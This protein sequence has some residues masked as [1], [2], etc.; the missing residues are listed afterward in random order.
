MLCY[1]PIIGRTEIENTGTNLAF[2]DYSKS[3]ILSRFQTSSK[4]NI[5][6]WCT[7]S[8]RTMIG[9]YLILLSTFLGTNRA[10]AFDIEMFDILHDEKHICSTFQSFNVRSKTE[11]TGILQRI[12]TSD[13]QMA[14]YFKDT[15]TCI[16][17]TGSSRQKV[18]STDTNIQLI[19]AGYGNYT[20]CYTFS[21][22]LFPSL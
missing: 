21:L 10:T 3:K 6:V 20:F 19:A 1:Q 12:V 13:A 8:L 22:S 4:F 14:N 17:C 2:T 15:K 9:V 11:C 18:S 16:I 5:T 7:D